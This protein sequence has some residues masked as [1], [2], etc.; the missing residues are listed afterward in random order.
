VSVRGRELRRVFE[1]TAAF[2]AS[3]LAAVLS[4]FAGP[5][6]V[7]IATLAA[8]LIL[9]PGLTLTSAM[10]EIATRHLASGTTRLSGA[11][12]TFLTIA[13][14]VAMGN[15]AAAALLGTLPPS[16]P[17]PLA[18]WT[19]W[20]VLLI[21]PVSLTVLLRGA[22]R[23]LPVTITVGALSFVGGRIGARV[24]GPELGIFAG[25]LT[26]GLASNF[27]ARRR[28]VPSVTTLV[29]AVLLIVPGSV[30][31][32]SLASL[33]ERHVVVGVETAFRMVLM[34]SALVAGLLVANVILPERRPR[35]VDPRI[36]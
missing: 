30:G 9:L 12:M 23:D 13:F 10:T 34:L 29:P 16:A 26:A 15:Q 21:A 3:A 2:V 18:A 11:V 22:P 1:P 14:G 25:A 31:F 33:L 24:L 5:S 17:I 28:D 7:Y 19:E 6:S 32:R 27:V 35:S 4:R 8:I 36:Q 20:A